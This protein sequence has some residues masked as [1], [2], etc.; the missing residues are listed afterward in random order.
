MLFD[1]NGRRATVRFGYHGRARKLDPYGLL[2]RDG[3]WY[4]V[5]PEHEPGLRTFRVDRIEGD[6]EDGAGGAFEVPAGFD[7][8]TVVRPTP[9]GR[10]GRGRPALAVD[11]RRAAPRSSREVGDGAVAERRPTAAWWCGCRAPTGGVP[12][13][14][15]GLLD[16]AEVLEPPDV[17]AEMVAWLDEL[18][19]GPEPGPA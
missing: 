9:S 12:L 17:R 11:R 5:G 3:F 16:H 4:V 15:V 8:A 19:A 14:G 7:V 6:V 2:T 10:R 13:V 1:A 18:A